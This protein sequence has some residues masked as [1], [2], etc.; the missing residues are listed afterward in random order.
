MMSSKG[1]FVGMMAMASVLPVST[2]DAT[3]TGYAG[4]ECV[5]EVTLSPTVAYQNSRA[6]NIGSS[7][8]FF[9][10]PAVQQGGKLVRATVYGRDLTTTGRVTCRA[11]VRNQFDLS[12]FMT[13][14]VNSGDAFTGS[15]TLDL[16]GLPAPG[17][18]D[19]G[20]KVI[21]CTMP[22]MVQTNGSAITAYRV[23]EE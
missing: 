9:A 7:Q 23:D 22:P 2:A 13:A 10:C 8:A 11:E 17:F 1:A 12:G 3:I 21:H 6:S 15:F 4:T 18:F 19:P 5:Q 14:S 16:G 20:S